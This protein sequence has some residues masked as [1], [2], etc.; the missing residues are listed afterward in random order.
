MNTNKSPSVI[1][2]IVPDIFISM[3][4]TMTAM[5][6][7]FTIDCKACLSYLFFKYYT[8]G[9]KMITN[10]FISGYRVFLFLFID[11]FRN[12]FRDSE[13]DAY[14]CVVDDSAGVAYGCYYDS[15]D[16][17]VCR[18]FCYCGCRDVFSG[19][20]H[21]DDAAAQHDDGDGYMDACVCIRNVRVEQAGN[22]ICCK[23]NPRTGS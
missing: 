2:I 6:P 5:S 22:T 20:H 18:F 16:S 10:L 9:R 17:D 8:T 4:N 1:H 15:G 3:N 7:Y 21:L 12:D 11:G 14:C 23:C 13:N 19:E